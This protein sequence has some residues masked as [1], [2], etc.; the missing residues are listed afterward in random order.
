MRESDGTPT[1]VAI[2]DRE[3]KLRL[4]LSSPRPGLKPRATEV[5]PLRG[6]SPA[7][8]LRYAQDDRRG[9]S[10]EGLFSETSSSNKNVPTGQTTLTKKT[11]RVRIVK[12]MRSESKGLC[13]GP[14]ET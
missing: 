5:L 3:V 4:K 14:K 6:G 7:Q 11:Q 8:I 10:V 1:A 9:A 2:P 13:H 12:S